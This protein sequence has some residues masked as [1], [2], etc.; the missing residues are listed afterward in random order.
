V[1]INGEI[2]KYLGL[3]EFD[4]KGIRKFK[5]ESKVGEMAAQLVARY[6]NWTFNRG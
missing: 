4:V 6:L 1:G 5:G 2:G 3:V